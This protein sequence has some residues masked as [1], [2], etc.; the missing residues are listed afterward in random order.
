MKSK[1]TT[2]YNTKKINDPKGRLIQSRL[3]NPDNM[4]EDRH[5]II[6]DL[7]FPVTLIPSKTPGHNH[8]YIPKAVTKEQYRNI[9]AALVEADLVQQIWAENLD[10]NGSTYLEIPSLF[11]DERMRARDAGKRQS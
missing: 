9:L 1:Q 11:N 4:L 3:P 2:Q 8:L 6:L 5:I 7:D 10:T